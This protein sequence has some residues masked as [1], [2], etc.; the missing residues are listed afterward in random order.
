M[1]YLFYTVGTFLLSF[2]ILG[3]EQKEEKNTTEYT[4]LS[5]SPWQSP[6]DMT[7]G[8]TVQF[9]AFLQP[10]DDIAEVTWSTLENEDVISIDE[11]GLVI[12]K[13]NGWATVLATHSSGMTDTSYIAVDD[14]VAEVEKIAFR[15]RI[16][17]VVEGRTAYV[18]A[19]TTPYDVSEIGLIKYA[20]EDNSIATV[21]STGM[22]TGLQVGLTTVSAITKN[23]LY[24]DIAAQ[25]SIKVHE[26]VELTEISLASSVV[27]TFQGLEGKIDF[28][29]L[30]ENGNDTIFELFSSD[31]SIVAVDGDKYIAKDVGTAFI[32]LSNGKI[33]EGPIEIEV[34]KAIDLEDFSIISENGE[35]IIRTINETLQLSVL[36]IPENATN[37]KVVW[38]SSD[39][40][41]A[42]VD[43]AG[44]I[45]ATGQGMATITAISEEGGIEKSFTIN[46]SEYLH[47]F[48]VGDD[49]NLESEFI[50]FEVTVETVTGSGYNGQEE[51]MY[52]IVRGN[53]KNSYISFTFQKPLDLGTNGRFKFWAKI[54]DPG[55]E[56][57][58]NRMS[59]IIR[60]SDAVGA[61]QKH[62]GF[63][64]IDTEQYGEWVQYE[65]DGSKFAGEPIDYF[66][67]NIYCNQANADADGMVMYFNHLEGTYLKD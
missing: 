26:L 50:P 4:K 54:E 41:I 20:M 46:V 15:E 13:T 64:S 22:V 67:V 44:L 8:D 18:N 65:F 37:R 42:T 7:M 30:P 6:V 33:T 66:S 48:T 55:K 28:T 61:D 56:I 29:F 12:A 2:L 16:T 59:I 47:Y 17:N 25:A 51:S 63:V 9:M 36:T 40:T 21:D 10:N 53:H 14:V 35:N 49:S 5:I 1:K 38:S 57:T 23:V 19:Y 52:K 58:N 24:E 45:T 62:L 34:E 43:N 31:T 39:E 27:N 3:C 32:F 11:N 60:K